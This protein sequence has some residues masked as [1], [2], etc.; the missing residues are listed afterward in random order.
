MHIVGF[1][2]PDNF[3][4][5]SLGLQSVF[6][7]SNLALGQNFYHSEIFSVNGGLVRSSSGSVLSTNSALKPKIVDTWVIVG[8]LDPISEPPSGA[9]ID[10]IL[11]I[12]PSARRVASVCTGAFALAATGLVNDSRLTTHWFFAKELQKQHPQLKV[13][14]DKIYTHNGK[15]WSSAGM[16]A[17]L[18]LALAL[19]EADLGTEVARSVARKLVMYQ[20]RSGGQ[21][22]HSELLAMNPKSDRIQ[23]VI[24]HVRKNIKQQFTLDDLAEVAHLSTR[25]FTRVFTAETGES[26]AKAIEQIRLEAARVMMEESNHNL[27]TIAQETGF[28]DRRHMREAFLRVYGAAPQEMRRKFKLDS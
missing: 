24:H 6:E 16:T 28:S 21:N 23:N 5:L 26:P 19:V 2:V 9:F 13:D 15:F 7:M 3:Q 17:G 12:E 14:A 27:E 11:Q 22:Q 20:Y 8:N 10:T 1:L 4:L 25:Q 18:D